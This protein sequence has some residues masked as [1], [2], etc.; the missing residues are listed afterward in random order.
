MMLARSDL[1]AA[2]P[3]PH[4]LIRIAPSA[5]AHRV[6]IRA[7]LSIALPLAVLWL[8]GH[9]A[10]SM[11]AA[12]GAFASLYGRDAAYGARLRMQLQAGAALVLGV[13]AGTAISCSPD[14]RWLA[15]PVVAACAFLVSLLADRLRWHPAGPLFVVF[16]AAA[17]ASHAA[18]PRQVPLAFGVASGAAL[19]A[20]AIGTAGRLR[21]LLRSA[22]SHRAA[23]ATAT[24]TAT[25]PATAPA[26]TRPGWQWSQASRHGVAVLAAGAAATATGIGHP[27]W[28]MVAA[29]V[30]VTG[31]DTNARLTRGIHRVAG[32][33]AGVVLAAVILVPHLPVG[34]LIVIVG[35]LQFATELAVG[36]NYALAVVCLTPLAL[37]MGTLAQPVGTWSLL[38]DR[39]IETVLGVL[40]G[41]AVSLAAHYAHPYRHANRAAPAA[42]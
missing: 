39:A 12:F 41:M 28:S 8:T 13:T 19:L 42:G 3:R 17:L 16:G 4:Q 37:T 33:L 23:A 25:A 15:V 18:T 11:Y 40:I 26:T 6:A 35:L 5:G 27:Y 34:A 22:S 20:V 14:R 10:W 7:G 1:K 32:T 21:G 24:A 38:H 30:A 9:I 2:L 29:V 36:R 31:V